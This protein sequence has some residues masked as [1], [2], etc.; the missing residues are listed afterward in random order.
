MK[1]YTI[2]EAAP[3]LGISQY[4]LRVGVRSG[5]FPCFRPTSSAGSPY[6]VSIEKIE[7]AM[8]RE[9]ERQGEEARTRCRQ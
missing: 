3:L 6:L 1:L 2:K 8:L 5:R 4:A 9:M 7:E